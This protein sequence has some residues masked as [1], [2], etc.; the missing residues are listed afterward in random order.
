MTFLT[1]DAA[2]HPDPNENSVVVRLDLGSQRLLFM[3]DAEASTAR[4]PPS[5][6]PRPDFAEGFLVAC[7]AAELKADMLVAGHHGSMTSSRSRFLDAV[8]ARAFVISSGPKRYGSVILPDRQVVSELQGRG[9]VWQ[10]DLD[11]AACRTD[12]AKIGP[13]N[14]REAGGCDNILVRI[15]SAG[16]LVVNYER[17]FD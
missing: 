6:P 10:T 17:I 8:G 9:P 7:C 3:G 5:V 16:E 12:M 4:E 13:D 1:A 14:A 2:L 15:P 11:D